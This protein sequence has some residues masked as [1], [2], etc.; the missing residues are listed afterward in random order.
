MDLNDR[1]RIVVNEFFME[2]RQTLLELQ[3]YRLKGLI[4]VYLFGLMRSLRLEFWK[5]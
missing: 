4:V 2:I 3:K 5:I 1:L